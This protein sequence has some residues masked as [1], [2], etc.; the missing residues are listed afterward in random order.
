VSCQISVFLNDTPIVPCRVHYAKNLAGAGNTVAVEID[1]AA[2]MFYFHN[3]DQINQIIH[4][5][6]Q[7]LEEMT[8]LESAQNAEVIR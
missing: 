2:V 4:T 3:C 1:A 6:G 7:A 8:R 5:L